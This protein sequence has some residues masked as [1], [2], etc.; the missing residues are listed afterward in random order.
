MFFQTF[1]ESICIKRMV[2]IYLLSTHIVQ[3]CEVKLIKTNI[4]KFDI[5]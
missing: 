2:Q 4:L 1:F 5:V 3:L